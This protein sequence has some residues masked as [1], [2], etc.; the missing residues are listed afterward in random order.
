MG[1]WLD[2]YNQLPDDAQER[3]QRWIHLN[4]F[5]AHT[6]R[7]SWD[8]WVEG[9]L[10]TCMENP[11]DYS[12]IGSILVDFK[13]LDVEGQGVSF[14]REID[15]S[16]RLVRRV[17][18]RA[19]NNLGKLSPDL[20]D[21][22][23]KM[24]EGESEGPVKLLASDVAALQKILPTEKALARLKKPDFKRLS[25][26]RELDDMVLEVEGGTELVR[27][28]VIELSAVLSKALV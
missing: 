23:A 12:F 16:T 25:L 15:P 24:L 1:T 27:L 4:K 13:G 10:R 17:P 26:S 6:L 5:I 2:A 11:L 22:V 9:Y 14:T 19:K 7:I 20:Q 28:S 18:L 3:V 8:K 21:A